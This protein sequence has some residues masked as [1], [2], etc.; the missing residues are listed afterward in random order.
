MTAALLPESSDAPES[1][2][3]VLRGGDRVFIRPVHRSD[4]A[5]ERRFIEGLSPG[6]RRFRFL[7][8]M[9]SPSDTLLRELTEI[10][11]LTDVAYVA[12]IDD[13]ARDHEVGVA[14]FSAQPDQSDCEFAVVVSDRWQNKGLATH[15]MWHL[16]EAARRRGITHMHSSDPRNND[17]MRRFA[18]HIR[19][20]HQRD[21]DDATQVIYSIE[22]PPPVRTSSI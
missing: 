1:W 9:A 4:I 8:S 2:T 17:L 15:L 16:V 13:E 14:R 3:E 20:K 18:A 11:P 6:A 21:P 22:V 19:L 12:V 7:E 10:D 5:L